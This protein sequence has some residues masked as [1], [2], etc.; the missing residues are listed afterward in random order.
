MLPAPR[1]YS[2]SPSVVP[3][4]KIVKITIAPTERAFLPVENAEY[5]ITIIS[6]DVDE[7]S[8]YEPTTHRTLT[9]VAHGGVI[10]FECAFPGE[11]DHLIVLERD[12]KKL[13]EMF[14]YSLE[15]D[16]YGLT[17]LKGDLH[18]HSFRSDG[19]RDPAAL[20]GHYR[21]QGYDFF[22]LT[23]HN[24]FYPGGE[25]DETFSGVQLGVT[26]VPGEEVHTPGSV[27]HIVRV[28]GEGS[29]ADMYVHDRETY[30]REA[31]EYEQRVPENV[32][33]QYRGR[34][35]RAMWATDRIHEKGGLAIFAHPFW[36][37]GKSKVHNVDN[38]FA[39]ILLRSGMFDAFELMG[40][41]S[42][43]GNNRAV[44][45]WAELREEGVRI[46]VVGSSD[47]HGLENAS[48]FPHLFTICFAKG[49]D[50]ASIIEA[51]RAGRCVAVEATGDEYARHYRCYGSYRLVSFAQYLLKHYFPH[52]QRICQGEGAAM[53]AY[54]MGDADAALIEL[55]SA[56]S[57]NFRARFLGTQAPLK[58][59][60]AVLD[61]EA[62]WREI[63]LNGPITKGSSVDPPVTRQI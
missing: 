31:A 13:G 29:V 21:E 63:H 48:T 18:G 7:I 53:R 59:S 41:M 62:R 4:D 47:V 22:A 45:M 28:G 14:I 40:G 51:V 54:A 12:E 32:P 23:D 24:R 27:V 3:A 1:N 17:P 34:Y 37:P 55:Q 61:F 38:R 50:S 44:A 52:M 9:A 39:R 36:R 8:Y 19:K 20:A 60:A 5:R 26:R 35:A 11:M 2:A 43:P 6:G 56:Q 42:Q 30:E 10:E 33:E 15:G 25:I 46:P 49:N 57:A 16:L 58:P